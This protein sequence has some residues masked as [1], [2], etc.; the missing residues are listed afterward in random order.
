MSFARKLDKVLQAIA[1]LQVYLLWFTRRSTEH[2][3]AV[4][5]CVALFSSSFFAAAGQMSD[6]RLCSFVP[7]FVPLPLP[8]VGIPDQPAN[9][10]PSSR[11]FSSCEQLMEPALLASGGVVSLSA[12]CNP[13][14]MVS[15]P[16]GPGYA[17]VPEKTGAW[18]L[19]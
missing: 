10:R 13:G 19:E 3:L 7:S 15:C 18:L 11:S 8:I 16:R 9:E 5:S 17:V 12:C 6:A 1:H 14:A 2:I 4:R